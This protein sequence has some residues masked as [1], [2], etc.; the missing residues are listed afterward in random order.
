M[1]RS[2][3]TTRTRW[4]NHQR[5]MIE[6]RYVLMWCFR[7]LRRRRRRS[8]KSCCGVKAVGGGSWLTGNVTTLIPI[9]RISN[10]LDQYSGSK[11]SWGESPA[12][13]IPSARYHFEC[14]LSSL[15]NIGVT[16]FYALFPWACSDFTGWCL[17]FQAIAWY[18]KRGINSKRMLPLCIFVHRRISSLV[19]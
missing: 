5:L 19:G 4:N 11:I 18:L 14:E 7:G 2:H 9:R 6:Q 3:C 13:F 12:F 10:W 1:I 16:V 17:Y 8:S 15:Q